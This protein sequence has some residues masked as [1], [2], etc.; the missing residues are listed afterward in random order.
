M[1]VLLVNPPIRE[2]AKPN[3]FPEGL[4]ILASCLKKTGRK[5][6]AVDINAYR[7]SKEQVYEIIKKSDYDMVGM[8]GL[9]TVYSYMMWF[10]KIC[11]EL[12]PDKPI[13]L[14]GNAVTPIP[15]LILKHTEAD[16]ACINEGEKT[17]VEVANAIEKRQSLKGISGIWY[18]EKNGDI[19]ENPVR[20][21]IEDLDTIPWADRDI[22]PTEIYVSN[23]VGTINRRKWIDGEWDENLEKKRSFIVRLSRGCPYRCTF[24]YHDFMGMK[25]RMRSPE[26]IIEEVEY[27][28]K[29]FDINYFG[30]GDDMATA[31]KNDFVEVCRLINEKKLG[32]KFFTSV[33][34]NLV[35]EEFLKLLKDNGCE[36]VCMG[37]ESASPKILKI[38]N[39]KV[40]VEQ[41]RMAVKLVKQYFGW[42]DTT[43]IIGYPGETYE[44]VRE[45]IDFCKEM[46]L[47]PEAVFYATPYPGT[48]LYDEALRRNLIKDEHKFI[49]RLNEQGE[50]PIVNFTDW[51]DEELVAIKENMAKELNAWNK[52]FTADGKITKK[53]VK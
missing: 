17:I 52:E 28:R 20:P 14:G 29:R 12:H 1:K 39:K 11:K 45:T 51:S 31:N 16:I 50:K 8:G 13:I 22:F 40:T 25:F 19:V 35:T 36:M 2:W 4:G 23:S 30:L 10:T 41:Q 3:C 32:I 21:A 7:Y 48:W 49:L 53:K 6:E 15:Q 33:R 43:F 27:L 44:T 34:A 5:V 9:I 38:M 42:A 47:Q 46:D 37:L 24:C 26:K 18:R